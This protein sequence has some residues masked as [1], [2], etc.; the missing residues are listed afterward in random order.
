MTQGSE[1][2]VKIAVEILSSQNFSSQ[3]KSLNPS[4]TAVKL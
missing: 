3:F 1:K 2:K 4:L